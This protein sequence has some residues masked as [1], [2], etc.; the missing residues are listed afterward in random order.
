[1]PIG[2]GVAVKQLKKKRTATK[3]SMGA[4]EAC[5]EACSERASKTD[6]LDKTKSGENRYWF[7]GYEVEP[8]SGYEVTDWLFEEQDK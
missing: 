8:L 1:M 7:C 3:T 5:L 6:S 2:V 4:K